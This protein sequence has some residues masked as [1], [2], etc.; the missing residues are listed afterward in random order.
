[1]IGKNIK[2]KIYIREDFIQ[3]CFFK[4]FTSNSFM[5]TL[6]SIHTVHKLHPKT[7]TPLVK[8]QFAG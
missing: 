6:V 1:M 8:E 5:F 3:D 2:N 7:T 4:S